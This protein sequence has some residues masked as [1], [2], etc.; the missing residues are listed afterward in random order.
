MGSAHPVVILDL[1]VLTRVLAVS[2][3]VGLGLAGLGGLSGR[4]IS[5]PR[6]LSCSSRLGEPCSRGNR[7]C[8][9][10]P[11]CPSP[12]SQAQDW[13]TVIFLHFISESKSQ[14]QAACEGCGSRV[15]LCGG[16]CRVT[17]QRE[18]SHRDYV[19]EPLP[20]SRLPFPESRA[21]KKPDLHPDDRPARTR[22]LQPVPRHGRR[23]PL[24]RAGRQGVRDG[25]L[26]EVLA[27]PRH[28]GAPERLQ[29][30][31]SG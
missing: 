4:S 19:Y 26:Q 28:A 29:Q 10:G 17:F 7:S 16:C 15:R 22:A 30:R 11:R 31:R 24:A 9:R 25:H 23:P 8:Q 6:G 2:C 12:C 1:T 27:Q 21:H 3:Q 18:G 14:G 5:A 13:H 20:S